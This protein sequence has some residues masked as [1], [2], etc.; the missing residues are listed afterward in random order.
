MYF[1]FTGVAAVVALLGAIRGAKTENLKLQA[2][3]VATAALVL[4]GNVLFLLFDR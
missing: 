1:I 2:I 3:S 4:F